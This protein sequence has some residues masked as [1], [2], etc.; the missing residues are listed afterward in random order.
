MKPFK[1]A[2]I[3]TIALGLA[4]CYGAPITQGQTSDSWADGAC[5]KEK[6]GVTLS[7]DYLGTVTTHCA[8]NF[9][10]SGW[11]LFKA[12]GFD[13]R[14][15]QKYPTAFACQIN[16]EPKTAKCDDSDASGAYWGYY[17][18]SGGKWDYATT[19]ASDHRS[20]CGETEGWVYMQTEKTVSHLPTPPAFTCN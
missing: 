13:V 10:G 4:G 6:P 19:G 8:L 5:S 11:E 2:L 16:G 1:L 7:V 9:T 18:L 20:T 3:T 17:I 15:T 12:A 14:G